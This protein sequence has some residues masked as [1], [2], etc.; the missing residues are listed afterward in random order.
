M[1][2]FTI[3]SSVDRYLP[4]VIAALVLIGVAS[5]ASLFV[6]FNTSSSDTDTDSPRNATTTAPTFPVQ[7]L[8][9]WNGQVARFLDG[10][11][12]PTEIYDIPVA[13]LPPEVQQELSLGI[14]V[15]AEE[16][17]LI[18]LENFSS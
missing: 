6:P 10:E 15:T 4:A 9:G 18:I 3:K 8:K 16:D 1:P 12:Q 13:S 7:T 14:T 11:D 5:W 17:L 2:R